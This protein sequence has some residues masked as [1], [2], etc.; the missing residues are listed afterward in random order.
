MQGFEQAPRVVGGPS[1][2]S[3]GSYGRGFR[4]VEQSLNLFMASV[5]AE[6]EMICSLK[7][8]PKTT[9]KAFLNG[10]N[11]FTLLPSPD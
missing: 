1:G 5:L 6:L 11:N 3:T 7:Q 8:E 2:G 9:L 10:N 4:C